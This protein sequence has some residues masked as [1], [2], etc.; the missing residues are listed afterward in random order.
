ME[1]VLLFIFA[2]LFAM[3]FNYGMPRLQTRF[4]ANSR[5]GKYASGYAGQTAATAVLVFAL[6]V[7][8]SFVFSVAGQSARVGGV[9]VS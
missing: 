8:V 4:A 9:S 5:V 3:G 1:I 6:L 2:V 7:A